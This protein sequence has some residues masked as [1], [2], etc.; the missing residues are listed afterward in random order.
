MISFGINIS[1]CIIIH[2]QAL[3]ECHLYGDEDLNFCTQTIQ[4]KSIGGRLNRMGSRAN[5]TFQNQSVCNKT[6]YF[7]TISDLL[8]ASCMDA[9][10]KDWLT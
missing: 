6:I 4:I 1:Y 2:V 3:K 5:R 7:D 10:L 8:R 9:Q